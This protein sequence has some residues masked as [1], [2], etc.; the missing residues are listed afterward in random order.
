MDHAIAENTPT[1]RETLLQNWL[2]SQRP[3][4]EQIKKLGVFD[5]NRLIPMDFLGIPKDFLGPR[6][7]AGPYVCHLRRKALW[8]RTVAL[9]FSPWA[10]AHGL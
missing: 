3:Y 1:P 10:V 6:S 2:A 5:R 7:S 8:R 9:A 4:G